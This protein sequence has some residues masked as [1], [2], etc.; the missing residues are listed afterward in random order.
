MA[1]KFFVIILI[2]WG[3][4]AKNALFIMF[5]IYI[6]KIAVAASFLS[7]KKKSLSN[8]QNFGKQ[9]ETHFFDMMTFLPLS[10]RSL[11]KSVNFGPRILNFEILSK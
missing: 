3:S 11:Q 8:L 10:F 7:N 4:R 5:M 9:L 1:L 6:I 2:F